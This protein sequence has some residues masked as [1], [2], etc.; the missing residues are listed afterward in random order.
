MAVERAGASAGRH[1]IVRIAQLLRTEQ[2]A[3]SHGAA[4]EL[5]AFREVLQGQLVDID[6]FGVDDAHTDLRESVSSAGRLDLG[7]LARR[8]ETKKGPARF[9]N[10]PL[11][12]CSCPSSDRHD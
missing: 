7:T 8:R 5:V 1:H 6:Y 3:D 9:R 4:L 11:V 2:G 10:R 12:H